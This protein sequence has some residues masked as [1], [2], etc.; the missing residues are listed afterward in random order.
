MQTQQQ[1]YKRK[2]QNLSTSRLQAAVSP[3]APSGLWP[4]VVSQPA[5]WRPPLHQSYLLSQWES[6]ETL[7]HNTGE[8]TALEETMAHGFETI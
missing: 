6:L 7:K 5:V 2:T 8:P 4:G 3:P 1:T